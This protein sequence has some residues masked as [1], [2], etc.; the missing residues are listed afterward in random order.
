MDFHYNHSTKLYTVNPHALPTPQYMDRLAAICNEL[1]L[2]IEE[3]HYF[4]EISKEKYI[5]PLF[6]F[7]PPKLQELDSPTICPITDAVDFCASS[8]DA[9][10]L[11]RH[12]SSIEVRNSSPNQ[13]ISSQCYQAGRGNSENDTPNSSL[14]DTQYHSK[15]SN[16]SDEIFQSRTFEAN[17]DL[18]E[19]VK[20]PIVNNESK[21][22]SRA[23]QLDAGTDFFSLNERVNDKTEEPF[24]RGNRGSISNYPDPSQSVNLGTSVRVKICP[25]CNR[26]TISYY[27][28]CQWCR[29]FIP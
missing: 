21:F 28:A 5:D 11:S 8:R 29:Y 14:S 13:S 26:E 19:S 24:A 20:A 23:F 2:A 18:Y 1:L 17:T 15:V 22:C 4:E 16:C 27:Q 10:L 12:N 6:Y 9:S 3:L 7:S 25:K